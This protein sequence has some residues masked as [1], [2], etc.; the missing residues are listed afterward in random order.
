MSRYQQISTTL[1]PESTDNPTTSSNIGT[2]RTTQGSS[3]N[4]MFNMIY[5]KTRQVLI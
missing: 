4:G 5:N 3:Y 2:T 1:D